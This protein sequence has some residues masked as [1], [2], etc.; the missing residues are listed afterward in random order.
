MLGFY[1]IGWQQILK[2]LDLTL[3]FANKAVAVVWGIIWGVVF[4]REVITVKMIAGALIVI[5]GVVLYSLADTETGD[6]VHNE[7]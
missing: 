6:E 5:A 1:A 4:F 3:A 7:R 2:H